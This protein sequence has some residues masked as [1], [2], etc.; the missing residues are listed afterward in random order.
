MN[1]D[2]LVDSDCPLTTAQ[3]EHLRKV[4]DDTLFFHGNFKIAFNRLR[5]IIDVGKPGQLVV[6]CGPTNIGKTKLMKTLDATLM[7]DA[8]RRKLPLW[9]SAYIRLPS[10]ANARFDQGETHFRTLDALEEPLLEHKVYYE[11]IREGAIPRRL[12]SQSKRVPTHRTMFRAVINRLRQGH[13]AIFFDEAGEL[14]QSLKVVSLR[15][16][17][18]FFKQ[19]ADLGEATAV[20]GGGPEIGPILWESGQLAARI[21]LIGIDPYLPS[22]PDDRR[23]FR[24][25]LKAFEQEL[26]SEYIVPGT[27]SN[28]T[29]DTAMR[30]SFGTFGLVVD[31][32]VFACGSMQV[33]REGA[34]SWSQLEPALNS[35]MAEIGP[36]VKREHELW[37][38]VKNESLRANFWGTAA[39]VGFREDAYALP[40]KG[41]VANSK[42]AAPP[43]DKDEVLVE[44]PP[45]TPVATRRRAQKGM[46]PTK[47]ARRPLGEYS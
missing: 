24:S 29:C 7:A 8:K 36:A 23:T 5:E 27:F 35:R 21:K 18:N 20:L 37:Q 1:V 13:P 19:V 4:Q 26:G 22:N 30:L 42:R 43:L 15:E 3:Y 14:P 10:P 44:A 39:S 16:A 32:T 33:S 41:R 12:L 9:G 31:T 38:A 17:V 6:L 47:P 28:A 40:S 46:H 2:K 11:D 25:L 34:L 45:G